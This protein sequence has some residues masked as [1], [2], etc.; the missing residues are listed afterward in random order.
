MCVLGALVILSLVFT[1]G[2]TVSAVMG[3]EGDG[4]D[5]TPADASVGFVIL[6]VDGPDSFSSRRRR[7]YKAYS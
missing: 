6:G 5:E 4:D 3:A 1:A 2:S 7:I